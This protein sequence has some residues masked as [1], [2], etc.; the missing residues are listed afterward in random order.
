M[1]INLGSGPGHAFTGAVGGRF[2]TDRG[3]VPCWVP[4]NSTL[5]QALRQD[6]KVNRDARCL[7][8]QAAASISLMVISNGACCLSRM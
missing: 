5:E 3:L 2:R 1:L 6:L 4:P 8:S 7:A